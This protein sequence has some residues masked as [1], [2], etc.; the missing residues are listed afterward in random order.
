ML[1][2]TKRR[3]YPEYGQRGGKRHLP[4]EYRIAIETQTFD[5]GDISTTGYNSEF[6]YDGAAHE[7]IC[8]AKNTQSSETNSHSSKYKKKEKS[9]TKE[10]ICETIEKYECL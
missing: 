9:A 5:E 10:E 1:L 3:T 2:N 7:R 4:V 6:I 8:L